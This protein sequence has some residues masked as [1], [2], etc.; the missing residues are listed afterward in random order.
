MTSAFPSLS[1]YRVE[2]AIAALVLLTVANLRGVRE[3]ATIFML[4]TCAS[5]VGVG[6]LILLK[7]RFA[8]WY[9]SP[10]ASGPCRG[11]TAE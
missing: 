1:P 11:T 10:T 5:I 6:A 3:S 2:L 4:P 8:G 7:A 9:R